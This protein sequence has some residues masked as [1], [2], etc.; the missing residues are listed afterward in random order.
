[1]CTYCVRAQDIA[2]EYQAARSEY[3]RHCDRARHDPARIAVRKRYDK[4]RLTLANDV[5]AAARRGSSNPYERYSDERPKQRAPRGMPGQFPEQS[6][7]VRID[8]SQKHR[9]EKQY[10]DSEAFKRGA[11]TYSPGRWADQ[12]GHGFLDTSRPKIGSDA[13]DS[14][15]ATDPGSLEQTS[16]LNTRDS[17][18][19][20]RFV[21]ADHARDL[22][23][24]EARIWKAG[25][26][27]DA[28]PKTLRSG[29]IRG[30]TSEGASRSEYQPGPGPTPP[31]GTRLTRSSRHE[32][33]VRSRS[34]GPTSAR[35]SSISETAGAAGC[36]ERASDHDE[37]RRAHRGELRRSSSHSSLRSA[38]NLSSLSS[39][40][41]EVER[42]NHRGGLKHSSSHAALRPSSDDERGRST[43]RGTLRHSSSHASMRHPSD[44]ERG[45]STDRDDPRYCALHPSSQSSSQASS[46]SSPYSSQYP[47]SYSSRQY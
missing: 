2:I 34:P 25:D 14:M 33:G 43:N 40:D 7:A 21:D 15:I 22:E 19:K 44:H 1:M 39:S 32:P 9:S 11:P 45:R 18:R 5:Q 8:D 20:A 29:S 37:E 24:E 38:M 42:S 41:H 36:G 47:S 27:L 35:R 10:R 6:Q 46:H 12:S 30:D 3:E 28:F 16:G 13:V 31:S 4:A 23:R 17:P 26:Y